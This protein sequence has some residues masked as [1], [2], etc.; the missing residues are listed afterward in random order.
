MENPRVISLITSS[1]C[2]RRSALSPGWN[3]PGSRAGWADVPK[4]SASATR[5]PNASA[6]CAKTVSHTGNR[7]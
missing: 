2:G 7:C 3:A 6:S 5:T 1:A 4:W